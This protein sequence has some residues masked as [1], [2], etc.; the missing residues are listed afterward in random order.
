MQDNLKSPFFYSPV[1]LQ[2]FN[3]QR[4]SHLKI[5]AIKGIIFPQISTAANMIFFF[6]S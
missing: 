6:P 3:Y 2:S 4:Y 1:I 5:I